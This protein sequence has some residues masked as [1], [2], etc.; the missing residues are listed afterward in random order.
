MDTKVPF[1]IWNVPRSSQPAAA[2]VEYCPFYTI[3]YTFV[4]RFNISAGSPF[5]LFLSVYSI[6]EK[7]MQRERERDR[8]SH[9]PEAASV[10]IC[11]QE[12]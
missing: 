8:G 11:A 6:Y 3:Y 9:S 5:P 10:Y 12:V 7:H 1:V 2:A 4:K